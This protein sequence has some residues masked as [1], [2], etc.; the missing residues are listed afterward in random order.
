[1]KAASAFELVVLPLEKVEPD[2]RNVRLDAPTSATVETLRD[3]LRAALARGEEYDE[4][5][6]VY[7]I[8]KGQYR[9]KSGHRRFAAAQGLVDR[10]HFHIVSPPQNEVERLEGQLDDNLNHET[11]SD[12]E[13]GMALL[14]LQQSSGCSLGQL[15]ARLQERGI[16]PRHV[17][18]TWVAQK[19][20]LVKKLTPDVQRLVHVGALGAT[21]AYEMRHIP[22]R[23]Q[24]S[25][26]QRVLAEGLSLAQV[27]SILG[28][29]PSSTALPLDQH[30]PSVDVH[31]PELAQAQLQEALADAAARQEGAKPRPAVDLDRR[32]SPVQLR[33]ALEPTRMA[34]VPQNPAQEQEVEQVDASDWA[35]SRTDL[36]RAMARDAICIGQ[37]SRAEAQRLADDFVEQVSAAPLHAQMALVGVRNM[38]SSPSPECPPAVTSFLR[39]W[40]RKLD[41]ELERQELAG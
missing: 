11:L 33:F 5:I 37:R 21:M 6:V 32:N 34:V 27:R 24:D 12:I 14:Q 22:L 39:M 10:L 36:H 26:A 20:D 18:K 9:I 38:L 13:I 4:P 19:I 2:P 1:M 41:Q 40:L 23:D 7:P 30:G 15:T 31:R 8:R 25:F 17:S 29:G 35:R 16:V 3:S 28:T